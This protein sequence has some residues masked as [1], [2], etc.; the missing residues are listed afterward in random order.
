MG[1]NAEETEKFVYFWIEKLEEIKNELP[2]DFF[3]TEIKDT[4]WI[5]REDVPLAWQEKAERLYRETIERFGLKPR[6][7]RNYELV[8][9]VN[10]LWDDEKKEEF[11]SLKRKYP[12]SGPFKTPAIKWDGELT[13]CCFDPTF[14]LSLGNLQTAT[15][16]QLWFSERADFIRKEMIKGN[17]S[18]IKTSSGW[19]KCE[20][21]PRL[22]TPVVYVDEIVEYLEALGERELVLDFLSSIEG[23]L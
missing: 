2:G 11:S 22:D 15:F 16:E 4:I 3:H 17:F 1:A 20:Q 10:N 23:G 18:A 21:C 5:K 9:S 6:K 12:C 14:E 19:N 7:E 8:V 13:I